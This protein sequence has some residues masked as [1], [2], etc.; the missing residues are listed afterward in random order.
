MTRK[1]VA[2]YMAQHTV[3]VITVRTQS[4]IVLGI[5]RYNIVGSR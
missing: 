1:Q 3:Q 5:R 2:A 4:S